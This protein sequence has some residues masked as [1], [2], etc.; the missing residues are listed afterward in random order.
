ML[1]GNDSFDVNEFATRK[2][3]NDTTFKIQAATP[4]FKTVSARKARLESQRPPT[5]T[6]NT[7]PQ[8]LNSTK[9]KEFR[10]ALTNNNELVFGREGL[11]TLCTPAH[12]DLVQGST[13]QSAG[14]IEFNKQNQIIRVRNKSGDFKPD[15]QSLQFVFMVIKELVAKNKLQIAD[16][17]IINGHFSDRKYYEINYV[18]KTAEL[19]KEIEKLSKAYPPK[20]IPVETAVASDTSPMQTIGLFSAASSERKRKEIPF[21]LPEEKPGS[22]KKCH[23]SLFG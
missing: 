18:A 13:C 17:I 4:E 16:E 15:F 7:L 10:F 14:N 2:S 1:S 20:I 21:D 23:R 22:N 12:C 11:P 6:A 5:Y 3:F 8:L 9:S 19:F